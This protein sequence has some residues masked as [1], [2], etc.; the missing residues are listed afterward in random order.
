[1]VFALLCNWSTFSCFNT[2][3]WFFF[4][5]KKKR[6]KNRRLW[7]PSAQPHSSSADHKEEAWGSSRR[8]N[9]HCL[10]TQQGVKTFYKV[11]FVL[12]FFFPLF[13]L[14]AWLGFRRL[15][16]STWLPCIVFLWRERGGFY[17]TPARSVVSNLFTPISGAFA[18]QIPNNFV[19]LAE[20]TGNIKMCLL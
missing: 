17:I 12:F 9:T 2:D 4:L 15:E 13:R 11:F 5:K 20:M 16:T 19:R 18:S 14:I 8:I 6:G 7:T 3:F 1:M 10:L